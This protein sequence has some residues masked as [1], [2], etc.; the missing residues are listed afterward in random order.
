MAKKVKEYEAQIKSLQDEI[1]TL[2]KV[3]AD[4]EQK[5]IQLELE[6]DMLKGQLDDLEKYSD[7][8]KCDALTEL[9]Y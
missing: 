5:V 2:K 9:D 4:L 7:E 8:E 3:K 6:N 1:K